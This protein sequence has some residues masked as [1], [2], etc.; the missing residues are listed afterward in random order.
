MPMHDNVR[1]WFKHE[2]SNNKDYEVLD[3]TLVKRQTIY[4]AIKQLS[5]GDI[6]CAVYLVRWSRGYYN[7][8]YKSMTEHSGPCEVECPERIFK[9]L[10][11]LTDENDENGWA[12]EWRKRVSDYYEAKKKLKGDFVFKLNEPMLFTSGRVFQYFHKK[13]KT[14]IAGNLDNGKFDGYCLVRISNLFKYDFERV[15]I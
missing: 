11:P 14:I 6:F 10:T 8:S 4:A 1:N 9:L 13:G 5:T 7:F 12:R 3:V 15:A 2:W